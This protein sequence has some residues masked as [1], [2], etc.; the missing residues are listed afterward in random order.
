M[1]DRE[2]K[3]IQLAKDAKD[4]LNTFH[5]SNCKFKNCDVKD[6]LTHYESLMKEGKEP[7]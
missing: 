1:S 7:Q 2:A 6:W 5:S 3:L 4:L